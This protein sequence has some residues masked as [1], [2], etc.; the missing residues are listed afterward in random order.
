MSKPPHWESSDAPLKTLFFFRHYSLGI[1][2]FNTAAL[3]VL[4]QLQD[5]K[6]FLQATICQWFGSR[7]TAM[8]TYLYWPCLIVQSLTGRVKLLVPGRKCN[9]CMFI[10]MPSSK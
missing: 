10:R 9:R 5:V 4:M 7:H 2:A 3:P 8:E 1:P 6:H